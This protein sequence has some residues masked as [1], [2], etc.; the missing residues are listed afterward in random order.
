M[1]NSCVFDDRTAVQLRTVFHSWRRVSSNSYKLVFI[2]E[3]ACEA[4]V[5]ACIWMWFREQFRSRDNNIFLSE[6][7]RFLTRT[8]ASLSLLTLKLLSAHRLEANFVGNFNT[9]LVPRPNSYSTRYL[10]FVNRCGPWRFFSETTFKEEINNWWNTRV[11]FA[12]SRW[13][14]NAFFVL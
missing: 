7:L 6:S 12:C 11:V 1:S 3:E 9:V 13:K 10:L 8:R 5:Q 4:W 14:T 2:D